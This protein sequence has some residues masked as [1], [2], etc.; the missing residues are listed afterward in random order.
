MIGDGVNTT[1][2]LPGVA[3]PGEVLV[4]EDTYQSVAV[5]FPRGPQRSLTL[6]GKAAPVLA[7]ELWP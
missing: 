6:E 1:A 4:M 2:R 3:C 7:R 5:R